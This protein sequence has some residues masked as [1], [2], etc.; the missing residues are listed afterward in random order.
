MHFIHPSGKV[1]QVFY[2]AIQS[3]FEYAGQ[4][5]S[6]LSRM[7]VPQSMWSE[8]KTNLEKIHKEMVVGTPLYG[9]T[10][11]SAVIDDKVGSVLMCSTEV[12]RKYWAGFY[13]QGLTLSVYPNNC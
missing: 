2:G 8:V 12:L 10:F 5:C 4:K 11:V 9:K 13:N 3:G 1:D 6:A 7:Y